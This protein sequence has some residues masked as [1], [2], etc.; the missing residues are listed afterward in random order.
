MKS[1]ILL[2]LALVLS[3]NCHA[4]IVFPKAPEGGQQVAYKFVAGTCQA[5]PSFLG[6]ARIGELTLADAHKI[7][8]PDPQDVTSGSLLASAK[9]ATWRYFIMHGT[10]GVG[11]VELKA[12]ETTEKPLKAVAIYQAPAAEMRIALQTAEKLPQAKKQDYEFRY[13]SMAPILFSAVWLHGETNDIVIPL[14]ETYGRYNAYQAYSEAEIVNILQPEI[15]RNAEVWAKFN[16]Q[17]QETENTFSQAMTDYD[18][19]HGGKCGSISYAGLGGP[20]QVVDSRVQIFKL[21]G[22]SS[23][24][25]AQ[26]Y[27]VKVT[28]GDDGLNTMKQVEVL[29][30]ITQ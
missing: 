27:K 25:G 22:T 9:P 26:I 3:C 20:F 2:C 18:K 1:K 24:C 14:P 13:L 29:G 17:K 16:K 12:D 7:Y 19:A 5:T 15:K 21:F 30:K 11:L 4:A 8:I 23:E 28:Y 10:N 6:G